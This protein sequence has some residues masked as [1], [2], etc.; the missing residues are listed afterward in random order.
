MVVG[1]QLYPRGTEI[2]VSSEEECLGPTAGLFA[3]G[4]R[5]QFCSC[6]ESK[7]ELSVDRT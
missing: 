2:I 6:R 4:A 1:R 3:L 7:H 5:K